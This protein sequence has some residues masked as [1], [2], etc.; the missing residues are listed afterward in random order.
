MID[1]KTFLV[2]ASFVNEDGNTSLL[3]IPF[4]ED[5]QKSIEAKIASQLT[6]FESLEEVEYDGRYK[7]DNDECLAIPDYQDPDGTMKT[8]VEFCE[9]RDS[10]ELSDVDSLDGCKAILICLPGQTRY[11][12]VQRFYR[13]LLASKNKFY[14]LF[15]KNTY[16]NIASSA[17]SFGSSITA[18]YDIQEK[19]LRFRS[20]SSIRGALPKFDEL[21]A[22]GADAT[23]MKKFFENGLFDQSSAEDVIKKDSTKLS[24]LVWLI[25]NE[26]MDIAEGVKKFSRID[27]LLNMHCYKDGVIHFP[28]DVKRNQIILRTILGDVYEENGKVYLSNSKKALVPFE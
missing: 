16:S 18:I 27:E 1:S 4:G 23:M 13:S 2:C 7:V 11:V 22:M 12:L 14:G 5:V 24:R 9:G 8:F 10:G 15:G 26:G 20:T 19:K 6:A 3:S 28:S 21:Y 25:N 17:F